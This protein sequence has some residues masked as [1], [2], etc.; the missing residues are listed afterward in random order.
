MSLL[1]N[2][3]DICSIRKRKRVSG[4]GGYGGTRTVSQ[5]IRSGVTCWLQPASQSE[6]ND[7]QKRGIDVRYKCYFIANPNITEQHEL[8]ITSR[9]GVATNF[10]ADVVTQSEPDASAG[11]G[12]VWKVM[13]RDVT[14]SED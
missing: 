2:F 12:V 5:L 11:L 3:P 6:I 14:S 4:E 8:V 9:S 1:D 13:I 10:D 7:Y